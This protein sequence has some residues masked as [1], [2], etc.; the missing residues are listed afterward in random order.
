[1]L[2]P[3]DVVWSRTRIR[4]QRNVLLYLDSNNLLVLLSQQPDVRSKSVRQHAVLRGSVEH[5]C[6]GVMW[7]HITD[8]KTSSA[9]QR[10]KIYQTEIIKILLVS[11]LNVCL[12]VILFAF[13]D[14]VFF[15]TL[16][17]GYFFGLRFSLVPKFCLAA[18]CTSSWGHENS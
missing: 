8:V 6:T 11:F 10:G 4:G 3:T 17:L 2:R 15:S 7:I 1:M 14:V 9:I 13:M 5:F 18:E 12:C 16:F